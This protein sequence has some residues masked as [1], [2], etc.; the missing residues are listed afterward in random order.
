M[1]QS[2]ASKLSIPIFISEPFLLGR[3]RFE[4]RIA[5]LRTMLLLSVRD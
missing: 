4:T 2:F 1:I 5:F 3:V